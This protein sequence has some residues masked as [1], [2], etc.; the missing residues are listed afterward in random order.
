MLNLT[1]IA[2]TSRNWIPTRWTHAHN[3]TGGPLEV[4]DIVAFDLLGTATETK[5]F[6]AF[7]ANTDGDDAHPQQNVIDP[8]T[9]HLGGWVYGVVAEPIAD[10]ARGKIILQGIV[11]CKLA[12]SSGV[13]AGSLVS[14]A[15]G[16]NTVTDT[17]DGVAPVALAL[18]AGESGATVALGKCIFFGGNL[19][20]TA[21]IPA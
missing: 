10:N 5:T 7:D 8:A 13:S 4:G 14:P 6:A 3:R 19:P 1:D 11:D 12:G 17:T 20:T 21:S 9:A 15:N 2:S 18:V 16:V